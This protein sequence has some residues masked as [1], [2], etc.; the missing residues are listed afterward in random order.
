MSEPRGVIVLG[1]TG[2]IAVYK[3]ADLASKLRQRGFPIQVIMTEAARKFVQPQTFFTVSQ[4]PV[5][6]TLWET[7]GWK[8]EHIALAER[9]GILVIAPATADIIA[10][11]AHGIAD[12]A[13][14]T[15]A[16]SHTGPVFVFPAMNPRMWSNPATKENVAT[17]RQRGIIVIEPGVGHIACGESGQGRFPEVAQIVDFIVA[18]MAMLDVDCSR[19]PRVLVTAGPTREAIDPVR[20]LSNRST[21]RQGF[22]LATAAASLGCKTTLIAGPV[23]RASPLGV[24]RID[25]GTAAEMKEAVMSNLPE[26]DVVIMSAAVADFRPA[27]VSD[28]KIHKGPGDMALNLS[29]TEDI[30]LAIRG[31]R[32]GHQK[33][34]GFAAETEN[35]EESA[36]RKLE[37]KGLDMICANDVSRSDVG[38]KTDTNELVLFLKDGTTVRLD[39]DS[40][41]KIS[42][43]VLKIILRL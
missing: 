34:I 28:Q 43:E 2:S 39:K 30:L 1:V 12:D 31:A 14:S 6:T 20:F 10:K 15:Y 35:M 29:R 5:I 8:P 19:L 13:L 38:F 42:A 41:I 21:G 33:V 25:V 24:R 40:K 37:Q 32:Q 18:R 36:R 27:D 17:L 4:L 7:P 3:A 22:A 23:E 9:A 16:I 11:L 26:A